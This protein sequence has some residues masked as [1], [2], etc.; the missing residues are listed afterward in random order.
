MS[1][2]R[3]VCLVLLLA[4]VFGLSFAVGEVAAQCGVREEYFDVMCGVQCDNWGGSWYCGLTN[5]SRCCWD[6]ITAPACG[7]GSID[8]CPECDGCGGAGF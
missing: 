4:I 5:W 3:R 6:F 2:I 7:D 1:R 8:Q